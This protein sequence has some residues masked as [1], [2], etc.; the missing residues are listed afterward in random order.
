MEF[1]HNSSNWVLISMAGFLAVVYFKARHPILAFL[2]ARTNKIKAT[3][4]EDL[5]EA[6][7]DKSTKSKMR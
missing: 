5:K 2:D 3:L 4:E 7:T 6:L 1:L